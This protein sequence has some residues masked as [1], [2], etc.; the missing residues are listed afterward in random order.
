M[1]VDEA[2]VFTHAT[3]TYSAKQNLDRT[4]FVDNNAVVVC[5]LCKL[6]VDGAVYAPCC[7]SL[8]CSKCICKWLQT[9]RTCPDC[10]QHLLASSLQQPNRVLR[11]IVSNWTIH[12]DYHK[13]ALVGCRQTVP[14]KRLK[15]HVDSCTFNPS[16]S[17]TPIRTVNPSATVE[18]I[19]TASPSKLQG[20]VAD[21]LTHH[22]IQCKSDGGRL[23]VKPGSRGRSLVFQKVTLSTTPS[24]EAS[25]STIRRRSAELTTINHEVCG[26]SAGARAQE[27]AGLKRLSTADQQTILQDIGLQA[28]AS[29]PGTALA[30]KADLALP[31]NKFRLL[32][33]WLKLLGVELESERKMRQFVATQ[34]P[35]YLAKEL[36]MMNRHGEISMAPAVYFPDLVNIVTY[37]LDKLDEANCLTWS[38]GIPQS[39]VWIKIGGDH[40]GGSFKLCFQVRKIK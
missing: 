18:D 19:L 2:N 30:I 17:G 13:P 33:R 23:E 3:P 22:L 34:I 21:R 25:A 24:N 15:L 1:D 11:D 4:R 6:V 7:E 32:R 20:N 36:P 37:F 27:V 28:K 9:S 35:K 26:G 10:E 38:N 16:G 5:T 39:E 40:G 8:F 29:A 14:L 12:C 31:Y